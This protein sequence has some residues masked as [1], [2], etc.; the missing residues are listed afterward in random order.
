MKVY[1]CGSL[2]S[3]PNICYGTWKLPMN[4][5]NSIDSFIAD[6]SEFLIGDRE[7]VD[8]C[9]QDYLNNQKYGKVTIYVSGSKRSTK[10]NVGQWNE[11][12]Y[13]SQGMTRQAI[14]IEKDFRMAEDADIG[15]AI[16]DG[17][18]KEAFVDM[19]YFVA[20]GKCMRL[21]LVPEDKWVNINNIE[22]LQQFV[23]EE[24]KIDSDVIIRIMTRCG[25]S[26][27]M[28]DFHSV[29]MN[30]SPYTLVDVICGAPINLDAKMYM[31]SRLGTSMNVKWET[32]NSV[33]E[34]ICLGKSTKRI[35]H[36]I[37]A[38]VDYRY[39]NSF[40]KYLTEMYSELIKAKNIM[41]GDL[42]R[43]NSMYLF[44]EWYDTEEFQL[45]SSSCGIFH[46][47]DKVKK[48][49]ENEEN[50]DDS[51]ESYYRMEVWDNYDPYRKK[52]RYD[53]YFYNGEVCW[54]QK[55]IP[56]EAENGN[57]YYWP[58]SRKFTGGNLDIYLETPY[59]P[60]DV[61]RIDCRP[62]GP[63]FYA[64]ILEARNQFDCCF[65]NILFKIP[66]TDKWDITPLKHKLFYKD[67]NFGSYEPII[68]PLYRIR[69]VEEDDFENDAFTEYISKLFTLSKLIDGREEA[70]S[71]VWNSYD[72]H[73]YD[74]MTEEEMM[75]LF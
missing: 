73:H 5:C 40:W 51:G 7:H 58:E 18:S 25:F 23:G 17:V 59:K 4:I 75:S 22:S 50:E 47:P 41:Y 65:P 14:Y 56:K 67:I 20:L 28:I 19:L 1:V 72:E 31:L 70:A 16:W 24:S 10:Y 49:I 74:E 42:W 13:R 12:H 26:K 46:N 68:S 48:Y 29:E 3:N 62:F 32:Y 54:F 39:N 37:R 11:K 43:D 30:I 69:K 8:R 21:Y 53:Y 2:R 55:Y 38:I 61:V 36:D 63:V 44:S 66:Y 45:K 52:E 34:N 64:M 35:K 57:I 27:E 60:G 6:G 15:V 33:C 71:A 9:V